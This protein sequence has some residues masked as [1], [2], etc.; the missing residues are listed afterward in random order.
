LAGQFDDVGQPLLVVWPSG[1]AALRRSV[2]SEHAADPPLG[3][4][5]LRSNV[6]DAAPLAEIF[7]IR[8][9]LDV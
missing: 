4:L 3:Q 7:V 2:L 8:A 1:N 6:V 9:S 5:Q